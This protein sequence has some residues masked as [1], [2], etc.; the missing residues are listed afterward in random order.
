M[1]TRSRW[2][3]L[4]LMALLLIASLAACGDDEANN[5]QTGPALTVNE[6]WVRATIPMASEESG[7]TE[8][9]STESGETGGVTGAFMTIA[10]TGNEADTL[11][12]ASVD[13]SIAGTVEIHETTIDENDV[14]KMRPVEGI[15]I[16]ADGNAVLKPGSY[17]I[18]LL[19]VQRDLNPGDT[20]QITL[21][22][23][24]GQTL[25][26]DAEVRAME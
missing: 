2:I 13:A 19:N 16:P 4:V 25:T 26:V 21:E 17:H 3:T 24:S 18:M 6:P 7:E 9:E 11:I 5:T 15:E 1:L 10:N 20:V 23:A 14:M 22:F 8:G 12:R